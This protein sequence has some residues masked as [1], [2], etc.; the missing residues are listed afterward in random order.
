MDYIFVRANYINQYFKKD[1]E[2]TNPSMQDFLRSIEHKIFI[3]EN[4]SGNVKKNKLL[5]CSFVSFRTIG[6]NKLMWFSDNIMNIS[7]SIALSFPVERKALKAGES[8]AFEKVVADKC[9]YLCKNDK[10]IMQK[11]HLQ[12]NGVIRSDDMFGIHYTILIPQDC[13]DYFH[14]P[15]KSELSTISSL[16]KDSQ[17]LDSVGRLCINNYKEIK[18]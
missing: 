8:Y 2:Y 1:K 14:F 12:V 16:Q 4:Q 15:Q 13:I 10:S 11:T 5:L 3:P 17:L 6:D 18:V 9:L 7:G